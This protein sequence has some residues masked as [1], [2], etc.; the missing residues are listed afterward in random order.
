MPNEPCLSELPDFIPFGDPNSP[1]YCKA[2]AAAIARANPSG[3]Q[4]CMNFLARLAA[5]QKEAGAQ[6]EPPKTSKQQKS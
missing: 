2:A 1:D 4:D 5:Q 6:S 3:V